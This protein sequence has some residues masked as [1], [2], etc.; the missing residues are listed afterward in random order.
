LVKKT[1]ALIVFAV[2]LVVSGCSAPEKKRPPQ[3]DAHYMIGLA[4]FRQQQ[5]TSA[6]K[7][8]LLAVEADPQNAEFQN[9]LAQAY[10]FKKAYPEAET[11]Y[12]KAL[13]LSDNEPQYQNNLGALY[14]DM[15]R[16]DDAIKYFR[17]ASSNLL[18]GNP[19]V[20]YT[21][22]GYAYFQKGD[23][24]DAVGAYQKAIES[25]PR[26]PV[27]H[28]RLGEVYYALNKWELAIPSFRKAIELSPN[29]IEAHY[30]LGL[31][32]MKNQQKEEA[33]Q[34][35]SEVLRLAPGSDLAK[36]ASGYLELLK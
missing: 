6:L 35:F 4:H 23:Y 17:L 18:F 12:L 24:I 32:Y 22:M 13:E 8:F 1:L 31:A 5:F 16:W 29:Y 2:I 34:A 9:A 21:G 20:A 28:M 30:K 25:S 14:L 11:H 27:A 15:Q 10:Q 7:E 26:Y 3:G 33:K 19:G 36:L